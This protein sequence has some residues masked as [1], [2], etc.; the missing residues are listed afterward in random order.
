VLET[1]FEESYK[2]SSWGRILFLGMLSIA[3]HNGIEPELTLAGNRQK[4]TKKH[5]FQL[6]GMSFVL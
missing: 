6:C 4:Q 1:I 3:L 5:V 2:T